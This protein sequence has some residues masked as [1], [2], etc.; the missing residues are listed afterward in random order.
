MT[1]MVK[2]MV[3]MDTMVKELRDKEDLFYKLIHTTI[4]CMN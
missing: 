1:F 4:Y 3:T 2:Q